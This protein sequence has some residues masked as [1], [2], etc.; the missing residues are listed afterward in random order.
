MNDAIRR[1]QKK[2]GSMALVIA[3]FAGMFF[4]LIGQKA[5]AKGLILG[6]LFSI[7]NF[8]LIG[9]VLP[10]MIG[11][12]RSASTAYSFGSITFRFGLL[13]IPL[14]LSLKMEAFNFAAAVVGIFMVQLMILG[15]QLLSHFFPGHIKKTRT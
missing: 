10:K 2:Y 12:K 9:E 5:I 3:I 13:A 8:V 11:K 7:L 14:V 1:T 6:T 15:D 4:I